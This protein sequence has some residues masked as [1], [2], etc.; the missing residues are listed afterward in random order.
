MAETK[1]TSWNARTLGLPLWAWI[2]VAAGGA[3]LAFIYY[4]KRKA[5]SAPANTTQLPDASTANYAAG[6]DTGQYESLLA[7]I[8]DLQ[9]SVSSLPT[10]GPTG[11]AGPPGPPGPPAP[12]TP[13]SG[14]KTLHYV[15]WHTLTAQPMS[16]NGL[17]NKY[18]A[19]PADIIAQTKKAEPADTSN[20][21]SKLYQYLKKGDWNATLP[22]G[23]TIF[24][25]TYS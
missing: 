8:R 10:S 16:I 24:V 19:S 4:R 25:P 14:S 7:Q 23:Y 15:Q 11:P 2:P 1:Q 21:K 22:Q 18:N 3:G 12:G 20:S 9:G 17:A 6:L 5:A 13:Q